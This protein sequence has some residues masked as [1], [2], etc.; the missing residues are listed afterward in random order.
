[1]LF[2]PKDDFDLTRIAESGQC[3]R[4]ELQKDGG[5]RIPFRNSCLYIRDAGD[6]EFELDC[7]EEEFHTLWR[8][9]FDLDTDYSGIRARVDKQQDPFLYCAVQAE[10]GIRILRQDPWETLVSFIISQNRNIPAI[11]RSIGLLC[12]AAGEAR[13]DRRG[14]C[15]YAFPPPEDILWLGDAALDACRLGYRVKYVRAAARAA[16]EGRFSLESLPEMPEEDTI[17]ALTGLYGVG[18]KVASCVSLFGLHHLDA[19]P[20]DVWIRR[21]LEAEYPGGYPRDRYS[22][23]NGVYQQYMFA[24]SRRQR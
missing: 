4:W 17:A 10:Q 16:A 23:F 24:Y 19:F 22:P 5:Y 15:Y 7:S 18:I 1:M 12:R 6:G 13:E 3:F 2:C 9:Y 14:E 20:V 8:D 11:R 21:V